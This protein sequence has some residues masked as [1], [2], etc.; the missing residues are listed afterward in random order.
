MR[1]IFL[2]LSIA[3]LCFSL[4]GAEPFPTI[5]IGFNLP[6]T[7]DL[8]PYGE[9]AVN[10]ANMI[11]RRTN[12]SGGLEV[13]GSRY[14][15]EFIYT[16]NESEAPAAV[17]AADRLIRRERA[18]AVVGPLGSGRAIPVGELHNARQVPMISPWSTNPG[19][20]RNRPYV[21]RICFI[22]PFQ[23]PAATR[24]TRNRFNVTKTAVLYD[25][26]DDYS[27]TLAELYRDTWN[28][29]YGKVVA[30]ESFGQRDQD[31]NTQLTRIIASGAEIL[32]L[33]VYY[34]FLGNIVPQA[35]KLGWNK[36]IFG[37][38][39]WGSA[40]L[41]DLSNGS[42]AGYYFTTHFV[43]NG[44]PG[45]AGEYV[46]DYRALYGDFVGSGDVGALTYD[47]V[48]LVIDA[49][50]RAGISGNLQKDRDALRGALAETVGFDGITGKIARFDG[51]DPVKEVMAAR[52]DATGRFVYETGIQP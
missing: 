24:F 28:A 1:R 50:Q 19:T 34:N 40:D 35:R 41:W 25:I 36:P 4:T 2:I 15:L 31:F 29:N 16:D 30:F 48:T 43:A 49:I 44:V 17:K 52:I 38:D 12:E 7:G 3:A 32:Y 46:R 6:L 33:P 22:D 23:A 37:V 20:T 42:V 39:A 26:M 11:L 9:E 21:F 51:G 27:K 10:T 18:L 8:S 14:V 45:K 47:T 13:K 5:R